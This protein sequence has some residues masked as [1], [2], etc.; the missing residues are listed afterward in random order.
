MS[1]TSSRSQWGWST[2]LAAAG[3]HTVEPMSGRPSALASP[4]ATSIRKPSTPSSNQNR[5]VSSNSACTS[6][7][8]QS[9]SGCSGVNR[10]RYHWPGRPSA[11]VTRVQAGP[12][13]PL[14]QSLGGSL[15]V[16]PAAVTEDEP[17]PLGR[18]RAR[19]RAPAGT[20]GAGRRGGSG[21][22]PAAPAARARAPRAI[23]AS[24]SASVPNTGS[25]ARKSETS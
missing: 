5:I 20:T 16:G 6:G 4:W 9:R 2:T 19:R 3:G 11:S 8:V 24:A 17:G 23:I 25:M 7:L 1:W 14:V 18:S 15:A 21:R 22:C 10:C 13:K 12:P